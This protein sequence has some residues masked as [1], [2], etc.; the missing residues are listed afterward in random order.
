[1]VDIR[2]TLYVS[3]L[4]PDPVMAIVRGRFQLVQEPVDELPTPSALRDGLFFVL[5][6]VVL[7]ARPAGLRR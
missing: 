1:M 7:L 5:I 4:L 3:R 2:P 6:F